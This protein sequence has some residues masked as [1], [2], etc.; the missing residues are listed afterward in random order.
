[1]IQFFVEDVSFDPQI[2][3]SVP[4]WLILV[5]EQHNQSISSISYIFCSD[6]Y[7]LQVN[8]DYL[9]HDYYTDIITFDNRDG[10]THPLES[11]IF[12]STERVQENAQIL[13]VDFLNELLRIIVHGVLHLLGFDDHSESSKLQMRN[14]EDEYVA[15]YFSQFHIQ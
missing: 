9:N 14:L 1:M 5:A 6:D 10:S 12:I 15:I 11:D 4:D 3:Q 8:R 2:L 7:L 13:K